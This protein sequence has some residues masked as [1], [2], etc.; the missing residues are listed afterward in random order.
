MARAWASKQRG[1]Q[2]IHRVVCGPVGMATGSK[3]FFKCRHNTYRII[4][5]MCEHSPRVTGPGQAGSRLIGPGYYDV[6]GL[7]VSAK[8]I[9]ECVKRRISEE[10]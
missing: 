3:S 8:L 9:H 5:N 10:D 4:R 2:R 7:Y 1:Q 6:A